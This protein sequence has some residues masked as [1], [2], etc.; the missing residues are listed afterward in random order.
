MKKI[1]FIHLI[2]L[3]FIVTAQ[4]FQKDFS[5]TVES[6]MKSADKIINATRNMNTGNYDLKYHRLM[7]TI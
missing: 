1:A 2:L 7:C 6:E 5:T 4:D 3:S